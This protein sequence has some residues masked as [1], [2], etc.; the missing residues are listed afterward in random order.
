MKKREGARYE[1]CVIC[2]LEWNVP[3]DLQIR[4]PG[5]ICP[6]CAGIERSKR[7]EREDQ[8]ARQDLRKDPG[9]DH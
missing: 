8:K 7:N 3:K 5:Y 6:H 1:T 4:R 2:G 9:R